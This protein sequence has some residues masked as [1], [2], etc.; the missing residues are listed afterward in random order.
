MKCRIGLKEWAHGKYSHENLRA[1]QES[2]F[3]TPEDLEC[4]VFPAKV[5]LK[6]VLS[7]RPVSS[8]PDGEELRALRQDLRTRAEHGV[9]AVQPAKV[10]LAIM[11]F[12]VKGN[13]EVPHRL[14]Q[15]RSDAGA[16]LGNESGAW[17]AAMALGA[18]SPPEWKTTGQQTGK[19]R[20]LDDSAA[21][22]AAGRR[23]HFV[24]C[25]TLPRCGNRP[26]LAVSANVANWLGRPVAAVL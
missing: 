16:P 6:D 19:S 11:L 12:P 21:V 17:P 23:S 13:P 8:I 26:T 3:E 5:L 10:L 18:G 2:I 20:T 7:T 15:R 25:R 9:G 22:R 24:H 1:L 4:S 14:D